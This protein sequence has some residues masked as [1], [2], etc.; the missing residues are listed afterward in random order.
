MCDPSARSVYVLGEV[1]V[2]KAAASRWQANELPGSPELNEKVGELSFVGS[3]GFCVIVKVGAV[4]SI[5]QV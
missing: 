4:V 2:A 5:V 1:Q 3:G